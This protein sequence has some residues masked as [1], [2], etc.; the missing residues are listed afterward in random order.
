M[1]RSPKQQSITWF[2][3]NIFILSRGSIEVTLTPLGPN[4]VISCCFE[5]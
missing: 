4:D 1:V 5:I 2:G 3:P